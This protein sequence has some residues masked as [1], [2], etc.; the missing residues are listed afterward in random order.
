MEHPDKVIYLIRHGETETDVT[1]VPLPFESP[2]SKRG[3]GQAKLL[4][5]RF[6]FSGRRPNAIIASTLA[7]AVETA[8]PIADVMVKKPEFLELFV[9][10]KK[11][12]SLSGM[13]P[14]DAKSQEAWRTWEASLFSPMERF[15]DGENYADIVARADAALEFLAGRREKV[16]AVVTHGFFARTVLVRA[17]F[18]EQLTPSVYE[19]FMNGLITENTGIS[20]LWRIGSDWKLHTYNDVGHLE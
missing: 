19:R 17:I 9:E 13:L 20:E 1:S 14:E 2:L 5:S 4:S 18:G 6:V 15:E 11:P 16:L 7:R 10:R 12:T 3:R 8:I